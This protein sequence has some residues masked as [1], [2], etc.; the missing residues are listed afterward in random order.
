MGNGGGGTAKRPFLAS[1]GRAAPCSGGGGDAATA[2]AR[3]GGRGRGR[4]GNIEQHPLYFGAGTGT[5]EGLE[6]RHKVLISSFSNLH[7]QHKPLE[8]VGSV[9]QNGQFCLCLWSLAIGWQ[10]ASGC[11]VEVA[12]C[13]PCSNDT[14]K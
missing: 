12:V 7:H 1:S 14:R 4:H 10:L 5:R 13:G 6:I 11:W 9:A 8:A 3:A 2:T